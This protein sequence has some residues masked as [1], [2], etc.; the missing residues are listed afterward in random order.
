MVEGEGW[1]SK[2]LRNVFPVDKLL[3]LMRVE[4][5]VRGNGRIRDC[6]KDACLGCERHG[7]EADTEE[8]RFEEWLT[9]NVKGIEVTFKRVAA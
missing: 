2:P 5:E 6:V 3:G 4:V 1:M 9:G 7:D 8:E